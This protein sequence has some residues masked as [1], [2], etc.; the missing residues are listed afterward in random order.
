MLIRRV[1]MSARP[2]PLRPDPSLLAV[3]VGA[4]SR[5]VR[6]SRPETTPAHPP[7]ATQRL[8]ALP[9]DVEAHTHAQPN[10]SQIARIPS[11]V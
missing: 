9:S 6:P 3:A 1:E 2:F 8:Y 5:R 10:N 11:D 4:G 7:L